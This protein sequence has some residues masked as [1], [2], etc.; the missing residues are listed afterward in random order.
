MKGLPMLETLRARLLGRGLPSHYVARLVDEL[1]DH[2]CDLTEER[3]MSTEDAVL[4]TLEERLGTPEQ[5]VESAAKNYRG[6]T[7]PG[8]HPVIAFLIA[9]IPATLLGF[10]AFVFLGFG[11]LELS[12]LVLGE[13]FRLEGKTGD[14]WPAAAVGA[15]WSLHYAAKI[16]PPALVAALFCVLAYRARLQP[17]WALGACALVA[18]V[19]AMYTSSMVLPVDP[20]KGQ[21]S[22]GLGLGTCMLRPMQLAQ[23]ATPLA[24]GLAFAWHARSRERRQDE[25]AQA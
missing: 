9:P 19:A 14:Q 2:V 21:Y 8:R 16:V 6:R 22:I 25:A 10:A 5:L 18:L 23:L 17:R 7:L 20:G 13:A 3:A 4:C 15:A 11:L 24:V 1:A 12:P